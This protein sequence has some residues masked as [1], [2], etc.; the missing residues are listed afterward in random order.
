MVFWLAVLAGGLFAWGAVRVGFYSTWTVF[1]HLLLA[2]YA[3][4]ILTPVIASGM[5]AVT[6]TSCG[7]ALAV[8]CIAIA[9]FSIGCGVTKICLSG[10][11]R[12]VF[13]KTFDTIIAGVVGFLGGFF[14]MGFLAFVFSL[15]PLSE[16][17]FFKM[18][19]FDAQGQSVTRGYI[20]WWC[21]WVHGVVGAGVPASTAEAAQTL[22]TKTTAPAAQVAKAGPPAAKPQPPA[23]PPQPAPAAQPA[24]PPPPKPNTAQPPGAPGNGKVEASG[25]NGGNSNQIATAE[26]PREPK[27]TVEEELM[28]RRVTVDSP[29]ALAAAIANP[30]IKIIEVAEGCTA[31]KL[32]P[33]RVE[34][35]RHWVSEGGVVWANN[36]VLT[37]FGIRHSKLVWWGSTLDC[38]ASPGK[39]QSPILNGCQKVVLKGAGGK[40]HALVAKGAVPLLGLEKE[41]PFEDKAGT[42]CWSLVPYGKGWV[43]DSKAVDTTKYDGGRFV[44]NFARFCLGRGISGAPPVQ[45]G[46]KSAATSEQ[47]AHNNERPAS[48]PPPQGPVAGIPAN[49]GEKPAP[50]P[51]SKGPLSGIWQTSTGAKYRM[52]DDGNSVAVTWISGDLLQSLT[53]KLERRNDEP[54]STLLAGS[55]DAVFTVGQSKRYAIDVTL[56]TSDSNSLRFRTADWPVWNNNGKCLG[57]RPRTEVWVRS[58]GPAK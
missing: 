21:D 3:A 47:P 33:K 54:G 16:V 5:T 2:V 20:C 23:K 56:T 13:P 53:G 8:M 9:I 24:P 44:S 1:V 55:L 6:S 51:L 49:S 17:G 11:G 48:A 32:D 37:V 40:A 43:S 26:P 25:A 35:L 12:V 45:N 31:D 38:T 50:P 57:T 36:D 27:E 28:R 15:T 34:L 39:D 14:V 18:L 58:G 41:I 4:I 10:P 7:Y 19:G 30:A 46:Q 22:L 42:P 52:D 29:D